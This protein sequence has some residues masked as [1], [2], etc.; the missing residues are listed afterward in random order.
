[1]IRQPVVDGKF[2]PES[3]AKL[4]AMIESFVDKD[5]PKYEAVGLLAPHAGYIYSGTV[6]G[7]VISTIKISDTVIIIGPNHTGQGK[8]YSIMTS[9]SWKT[10]LG[11]VQID[12]EM[13]KK[14]LSLS[15]YLE[16]DTLAHKDEHSIEVQ[17]PF[18]QYFKPDVKIVPIMLSFGSADVYKS[19]GIEIVKAFRELKREA[20]I[21]ASSD[22]SHYE[23]QAVAQKKDRQAIDAMLSLNADELFKRIGQ[24]N[25]SMCGY[26]PA[27]VML[28]AANEI[29]GVKAELVKYQ[30]SGETSGDYAAVV[31]YAGIVLRKLSPLVKLAKE[32][33]EEWVTKRKAINV[34]KV[35]PEMQEQAGTFV[36][37]K[38]FGELRG[39]I[40]TFEPTTHN[41]AEEI[42]SNAIGTATRDPRFEPV[43]SSELKDL[44]YTVDVLTRPEP[45]TSKQELDPKK[46]GLIVEAGYRRGLLLPDLEGVDTV[47]QQIDICRQKGDIDPD[48]P[49]KLYRFEV[50][51]Y[52]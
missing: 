52:K 22:M 28:T 8:P 15:K 44:E 46:Y 48:E 40:G 39:C 24:Q 7:A 43:R 36:C 47:D 45:V 13:A 5:A 17:V 27:M 3:A 10:P 49:V 26:A 29:G 2:Y 41:I 1:M 12:S 51:R 19:I 32:A 31:G 16:E 38:K 30:T 9:G 14:I 35:P 20:V 11:E 25:I 4:K 6:A 33:V 34:V 50:K 18:L 21:L 37:I 42:I 23:P